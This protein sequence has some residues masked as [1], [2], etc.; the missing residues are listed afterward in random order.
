LATTVACA[1]CH[2]HKFDPIPTA[3][4]YALAGIFAS[5]AEHTGVERKRM[6]QL[7]NP[8]SDD[9]MIKL[10]TYKPG[11][12]KDAK[13]LDADEVRAQARRTYGNLMMSARLGGG[14]SKPMT[15]PRPVAMGVVDEWQPGDIRV[16]T[17]GEIDSPG[18]KVRRGVLSIPSMSAPPSIPSNQSGRREL[19]DWI[20][21][22]DNPL[23]ARVM[24][25]RIWQHLF[26]A[27]IVHTVDNFGVTGDKPTNP[28]LLDHLA[29]RLAVDNKWSVKRTIRQIMLSAT[30][31][32]SATFDKA[33]FAVDPDNELH[34]RM[35]QRR[36]E[37]E[38]IRDGMLAASGRLITTP[39]VGS[40]ALD[41]PP[42]PMQGGRMNPADMLANMNYRS[43]YLPVF[44]NALPD[45]LDVFD[46]ADPSMVS[47]QRHVTTVAPQALF[48]LNSSFV[49]SHAQAMAFRLNGAAPK[50]DGAKVELAYKLALGRP[51]NN[52][53]RDRAITYVNAYLRDPAA[54][55]N[56]TPEKARIDAWAS[57]CQALFASAEF[58]YLN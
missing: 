32:Q 35:N 38:A 10:S 5:S 28:Q 15:A 36:L 26:G 53:E 50:S 12:S 23:T 48:M 46:F 41:L 24:A 13:T 34:W 25:N 1:R 11:Q 22:A 7:Q 8:Y 14:F 42:L 9:R 31:Q 40:I 49:T 54:A 17:R 16:L 33:K 2:D 4:Y 39:P 30:Y 57:L 56:K 47:G 21:R 20:T 6:Q 58:R 37:A 3:E 29:T 51:V 43:V 52:V 55:R 18:E 44:R 19:A 27:G 45:A